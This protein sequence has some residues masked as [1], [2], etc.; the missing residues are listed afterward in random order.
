MILMISAV[1]GSPPTQEDEPQ[2]KTVTAV[3]VN[4]PVRIDGVLDEPAWAEAVPA[5]GFTQREPDEGKPATESTEVRV[6]YDG[7]ALYVGFIAYDARPDSIVGRLIRRDQWSESDQ[8]SVQ[9]DSHHDHRTGYGFEIN[10]AGVQRDQHLY[11][12]TWDDRHWDAVWQSATKI[13]KEGWIAEFRIPYTCLRFP[14]QDPQ[15]WGIYFAR[16][17]SRKKEFSIWNFFPES[18][19]GWVSN[20]GHLLGI[21]GI[22]PARHFEVLPYLVSSGNLERANRGNPDGRDLYKNIGIDVKCGLTSNITLDATLNPDFGQVEADRAVLNLSTFEIH[23]PEKR[24]FFMEGASIFRTPIQL[25]YSR[26]IG[27]PPSQSPDVPEGGYE[28]EKVTATT[29]LAAAKVTGKTQGGTSIG[30]LDAVTQEEKVTVADSLEFRSSQVVEPATNYSVLRLQQDVFEKSSVGMMATA[31]NR[32]RENPAYTG[33]VD[34]D[35]HLFDNNYSF[36]GQIAGSQTGPRYN[37]WGG[38]FSFGKQAGKHFRGSTGYDFE[39]RKFEI[40]DLGYLRRSDRHGGYTWLQYRTGKELWITRRM[41]NNFNIWYGWNFDGDDLGKGFSFNNDMELRNHWWAGGWG[42][43]AFKRFDDRETQEGPLVTIPAQLWYGIWL[44][45]D[46]RKWIQV[47]GWCGSEDDRDGTR[48]FFGTWISVKPRSN[49]ELSLNSE[50]SQSRNVSRWVAVDTTQ[51]DERVDI[52]GELDTRQLDLTTRGTIMFTRD[53]SL[54]FYSQVFLASGDYSNLKRLLS[55]DRFG[56]LGDITYDENPDFDSE[57]F[58]SNILLRWEYHP[59][60]TFF[61]VWTQS[62]SISGETG[63][64]N[65]RQ[66]ID[67]LFGSHPEN[68]FLIKVSNWWSL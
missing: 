25:F 61:F 67:D 66:D 55:S 42:G 29:I 31:A 33:G 56:P 38:E 34:W 35:L 59:G 51:T 6:L 36:R 15:I 20:F 10:A 46:S 8:L 60:S 48:G 68:V 62:R 18:E 57:S 16:Y 50:Y 7:E 65:L 37:G 27:R 22:R 2:T 45:T 49:I 28:L 32:E 24:P 9:V 44:S 63:S 19:G 13:T 30:F 47:N 11:N 43:Y 58:H 26:R 5:T 23:Y 39:T 14:E 3:R 17:I 64:F 1:Y 54:Q 12:D 4:S 53:L 21:E 41:Y 40:N 52:F